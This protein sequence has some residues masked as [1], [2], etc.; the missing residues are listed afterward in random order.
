M[1][2]RSYTY[3]PL[4]RPESQHLQAA[5]QRLVTCL[6]RPAGRE[7]YIYTPHYCVDTWS[8]PTQSGQPCYYIGVSASGLP[9]AELQPS[10]HHINLY[11][12]LYCVSLT[13]SAADRPYTVR[14]LR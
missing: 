2:V 8:P 13:E 11:T 10:L 14:V 6:E 9:L 4:E 7:R 1:S 5:V 12:E 3:R